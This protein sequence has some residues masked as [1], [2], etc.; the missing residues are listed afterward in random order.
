MKGNSN[1]LM[2]I[3]AKRRRTKARIEEEKKEEERKKAEVARKLQR[4]EEL[5]PQL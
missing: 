4:L 1:N 2:K 5:E 3:G